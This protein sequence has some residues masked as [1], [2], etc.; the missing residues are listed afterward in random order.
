MIGILPAAGTAARIYGLPKFL[1][2]IPGSYLMR[3]HLDGLH[4]V[5]CAPVIISTSAANYL[6]LAQYV[7]DDAQVTIAGRHATMTQTVLS[8]Y[9]NGYKDDAVLFA[10]PDTLWTDHYVL[11]YLTDAIHDGAD[12]AV[13]LFE[14]RPGQH[15]QGGM[16]RVEGNQVTEVIDKATAPTFPHIWGALAWRPTFWANL[17]PDDPHVGYALPR[18]IAAGQDVR[19]VLCAGE[20]HDCGT[21]DRYFAC[22]RALDA[23]Y[24]YE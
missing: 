7:G 14:A 10:M 17:K 3:W 15:A 19:A 16:C 24:V 9:D 23:D 18:A 12:V 2:P 21:P 11:P 20:Y 5:G 1:L 13:A 8:V 22:I 6:L 4:A